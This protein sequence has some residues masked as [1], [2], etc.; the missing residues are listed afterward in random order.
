M[1]DTFLEAARIYNEPRYLAAAEKGEA[2]L[3]VVCGSGIEEAALVVFL[4]AALFFGERRFVTS[5]GKN[6]T[7][8]LIAK[9][10]FSAFG[11]DWLYDRLFVKP[12]LFFVHITRKDIFDIAVMSVTSPL[13]ALNGLFSRTQTGQIRWYAASMAFGAVLIIALV[14]LS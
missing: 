9:F 4:F 6:P 8:K 10:W 3:K 11:F 1:I 13:T 7:A 5:L 2:P 14:V 12:F